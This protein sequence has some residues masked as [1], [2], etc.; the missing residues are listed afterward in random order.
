[1]ETNK[2]ML[3]DLLETPGVSGFETYVRDKIAGYLM[4][5]CNE[6]WSDP[7]G[8]LIAKAGADEGYKIGIY[9]HMDEVGMIVKKVLSSGILTF[10]I[11]GMIDE[12]ILPGM[13]VSVWTKDGTPV[14]GV[15]G[16]KS[17]HLQTEE[18][19]KK[20]PSFRNM[21]IDVG[22]TSAE[23]VR[24]FGIDVGCQITFPNNCTFYPNGR[25]MSKAI[26][27]RICC[28]NLIRTIKEVGKQL[29]NTTLYGFFTA[30]E[31]IGAKGAAVVAD[32]MHLDMLICL[33]NCP[34]MSPA[35]QTEGDVDLDK[36]PVIRLIDSMPV[37]TNGMISNPKIVERIR[38]AAE[39]ENI[40]RQI[41][42]LHNT[43][44]DSSKAQ[45]TDNGIPGASI[46][47]PRRYSHT[48]IE[49]SSL[50]DLEYAVK[51]L[52]AVLLDI[53]RNPI[54]FRKDYIH[55]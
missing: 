11:S 54:I 27:D 21:S 15:I 32:G 43:Y 53:D 2:K 7:F 55:K 25:V 22:A 17:K 13:Q 49:M 35:D 36:G 29:K 9:A 31:E 4:E 37:F 52:N 33:D 10:E 30:Q 26:D 18:D 40:P 3:Q 1:M 19:Q 50:N 12:R 46:C 39:R 6:M 28:V 34:V 48:P 45:L 24:A 5:D 38:E 23:E 42:V 14:T 16:N 41:D 20:Q 8:N 44:L 51:L 47:I